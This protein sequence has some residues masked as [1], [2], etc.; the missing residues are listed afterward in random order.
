MGGGDVFERLFVL[1]NG[2]K[3]RLLVMFFFF[4][5]FDKLMNVVVKKFIYVK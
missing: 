2:G 5:V 3:V 1:K 4:V